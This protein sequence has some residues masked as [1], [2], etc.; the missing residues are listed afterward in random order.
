[1]PND[2]SGHLAGAVANYFLD[3]AAEEGRSLTPMQLIK[4][5]YVAHGWH[6]AVFEKPLISEPVSAWRYGPVIQ[7]LY[8]Q[9]KQYGRGPITGRA[10]TFEGRT[11]ILDASPESQ[12]LLDRV[13]QIYG[14]YTGSQLMNLTHTAGTPWWVTWEQNGGKSRPHA[15]ID[16]ALILDHF[17]NKMQ[18][19][20]A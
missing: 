17:K 14:R 1:M 19:A 11:P 4:L 2:Y 5:V 15:R 7:S 8:H 3:K 18:A 6:L 20:P 9:L 16:D 13:W 10:S 12:A